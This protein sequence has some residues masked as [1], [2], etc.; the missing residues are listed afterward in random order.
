[1]WYMMIVVVLV[2]I[3]CGIGLYCWCRAGR[4]DIQA[5]TSDEPAVEA[6]SPARMT[7]LSIATLIGLVIMMPVGVWGI[8]QMVGSPQHLQ[9]VPSDEQLV[10]DDEKAQQPDV[11]ALIAQLV[12][13]LTKQPN[14]PQGW[15]LLGR[16][17]LKMGR[18]DQAV[19]ALT[20][21]HEQAPE[22]NAKVAL[23]DALTLQHQGQVPA[24]AVTLLQQALQLQPQ[25][26]TTLWLLG[27]AAKQQNQL[28]QAVEYWQR[29]LPLLGNQP[30]AQQALR[31]QLQR[32]QPAVEPIDTWVEGA[33]SVMVSLEPVWLDKVNPDD[34]LYVYAKAEQ[35]PP[36]P[37][38]VSQHRVADLPLTIQLTDHMAMIPQHT[39]SQYQQ[40]LV[41]ARISPSGQAIAQ[42][43]DLQSAELSVDRRETDRVSVLINQLIP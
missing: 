10:A 19:Q 18:Y 34:V 27:Q 41:G 29:A 24:Q 16:T 42:T 25:S 6:T 14:N 38:A 32:I 11:D 1:M 28:A 33:L 8:Y 5:S 17:Y 13:H 39:L 23:A 31:D 40:V 43:G 36:M 35:G 26:V 2:S 7:H 21:L 12:D 37:L 4:M 30:E 20:S 9:Y 15:F 22:A 3:A